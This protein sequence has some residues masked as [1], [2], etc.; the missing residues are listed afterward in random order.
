MTN[1]AFLLMAFS[2]TSL[3][4]PG[5]SQDPTTTTKAPA[6]PLEASNDSDESSSTSQED[7]EVGSNRILNYGEN[8]AV[9]S[10]FG[11]FPESP[12]EILPTLE[13]PIQS[14]QYPSYKP[15]L[16]LGQ[17]YG[18]HTQ[19]KYHNI[20]CKHYCPGF[21]PGSFYCCNSKSRIS[22]FQD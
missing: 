9:G 22:L 1:L 17:G 5:L 4:S 8:Q 18:G 10:G 13:Y 12:G 6:L 19:H 15:Y 3:V 7:K 11:L 20:G 14:S 2:V 21:Y 16:P